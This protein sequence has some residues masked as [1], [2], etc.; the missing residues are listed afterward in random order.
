MKTR[1]HATHS[2]PALASTSS[3]AANSEGAVPLK[4]TATENAT[5]YVG[6]KA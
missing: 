1:I 3:A 2:P 4:N 5:A 6:V